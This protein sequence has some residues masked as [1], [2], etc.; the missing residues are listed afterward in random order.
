MKDVSEEVDRFK[1]TLASLM[2]LRGVDPARDIA[3][4]DQD[5]AFDVAVSRASLVALHDDSD[6]RD[7]LREARARASLKYTRLPLSRMRK[8]RVNPASGNVEHEAGKFFTV[9]GVHARHRHGFDEIVWDQPCLDQAEVGI[10]GILAGKFGGILHVCLQAKEEPGN[11]NAVQLS[12]TVQAT[13]SNYTRSHGGKQT[14]FVDLFLHP[15]PGDVLY[16][17]LQTEDGGRF[18][19][20]SN[21]NMI[22]QCDPEQLGPIPNH[23]IWLTLRQVSDLL[24]HDNVINACA[25]SVLSSLV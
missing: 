7:W 13:Y 5:A 3:G 2:P 8:W 11:I 10:L 19:Y 14:L 6:V 25:R 21:R 15:K 23:F 17:R 24:R 9:L 18:L 1:A 12:P 22:V 4:L 16:A 20:K